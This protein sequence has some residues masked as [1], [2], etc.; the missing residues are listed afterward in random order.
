[1]SRVFGSTMETRVDQIVHRSSFYQRVSGLKSSLFSS[2]VAIQ[3]VGTSGSAAGAFPTR[4]MYK[5]SACTNFAVRGICWVQHAQEEI[6]PPLNEL[7]QMNLSRRMLSGTFQALLELSD[8]NWRCV[9]S[10]PC[11]HGSK[12][13]SSARSNRRFRGG[14]RTSRCTSSPICCGFRVVFLQVSY[15][16]RIQPLPIKGRHRIRHQLQLSQHS[17]AARCFLASR[18]P[19]I[20]TPQGSTLQLKARFIC[21]V[22]FRRCEAEAQEVFCACLFAL[23]C[24]CTDFAPTGCAPTWLPVLV[25]KT[26]A[27]LATSNGRDF[28]VAVRYVRVWPY[29]YLVVASLLDLHRCVVIILLGAS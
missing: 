26:S 18:Q 23:F 28:E 4:S 27:E 1:M 21:H 9:A 8:G 6:V 19:G 10:T 25:S 16:Q 17:S 2:A 15:G 14:W 7:H 11:P 20:F 24:V 13:S 5:C 12:R 29:L 22:Q 3:M